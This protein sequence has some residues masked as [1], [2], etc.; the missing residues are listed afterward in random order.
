MDKKDWQMEQAFVFPEH[1]GIPVQPLSIRVTPGYTEKR[2]EDAVRLEGIYHIAA[3]FRLGEGK[4]ESETPVSSIYIS[5]IEQEN[6]E[7]YFE[8]A[9][10]LY[11]NLPGEIEGPV[12]VNTNNAAAIPDGQGVFNIEWNVAID[13][14]KKSPVSEE[15]NKTVAP[16]KSTNDAAEITIAS[17]HS[18]E[19]KA[20]SMTIQTN[21]TE[22]F[23]E[24]AQKEKQIESNLV[25]HTYE[26][27]DDFLSFIAGLEDGVSSTIFHSNEV[28]MKRERYTTENNE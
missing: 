21:V 3:R 18:V 16:E 9:I 26:S 27:N 10:P 15:V 7:A 1:V 24:V 22:P 6:D 5:D 20:T 17:E 4:R 14:P 28:F 11:I 8:Y 23:V 25:N 2:T 12:Q 13:S 19:E